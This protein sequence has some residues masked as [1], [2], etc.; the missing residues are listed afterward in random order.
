MGCGVY[1]SLCFGLVCVGHGNDISPRFRIIESQAPVLP[2]THALLKLDQWQQPCETR[3]PA[4]KE[5]VVCGDG[6]TIHDSLFM[7]V[8]YRETMAVAAINSAL[9][10]I[11][12][13][14]QRHRR[15]DSSRPFR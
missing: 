8:R 7:R 4:Y 14:A 12:P 3:T 9:L 2:H 10:H 13:A 6:T 5:C 1:W 11:V 15:G